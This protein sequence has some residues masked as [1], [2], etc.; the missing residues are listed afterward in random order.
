MSSIEV[1]TGATAEEVEYEDGVWKEY[2]DV[3]LAVET[4]KSAAAVLG[5]RG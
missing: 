5:R 4:A 1:D 3:L 2:S